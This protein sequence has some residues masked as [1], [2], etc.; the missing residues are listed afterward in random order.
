VAVLLTGCAQHAPAPSAAATG[1]ARPAP[2]EPR[3][4]APSAAATRGEPDAA[5]YTAPDTAGWGKAGSLR[6]L[7][8]LPPGTP[9]ERKL[10]LLVMIHGMGDRPRADWLSG[11]DAGAPVRVIMPQAP[12]PHFDGYSWFSY[13]IGGHNDP[14]KLARGISQAADQIVELLKIVTRARPTTGLPIIAGFS[15]GGML[16]YALALHYPAHLRFALPIAGMLPE[17][18]WPTRRPERHVPIRALHGRADSVIEIG[19]TR[20][21]QARLR[22]LGYDATLEEFPAIDHTISPTMQDRANALLRERL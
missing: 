18:L 15:Q 9:R 11:F 12:S 17:P 14:Q 16:S 1:E 4:P 10:P 5:A 7:E 8:I 2:A 20:E 13:E 3:I 19:A 6:F 22:K 21:L